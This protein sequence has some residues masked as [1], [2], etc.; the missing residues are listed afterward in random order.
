MF[1]E[2]WPKNRVGRS[3]ILNRHCSWSTVVFFW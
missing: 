3:E 1:P 2:T